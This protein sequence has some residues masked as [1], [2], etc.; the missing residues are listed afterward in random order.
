MQEQREEEKGRLARRVHDEL[1]QSLTAA[2]I[3]LAMLLRT[4]ESDPQSVPR[5][6]RS[7]M[8]SLDSAVLNVRRVSTEL[9]PGILDQMGL[10]P[11]LEWLVR[12]FGQRTGINV[13]FQC[14]AGVALGER[15]D[16]VVFRITQEALTNVARH[17]QASQVKVNGVLAQNT[18]LLT[19]ADDGV[20]FGEDKLNDPHSIGLFGMRERAL[21]AGGSIAIACTPGSGSL[22]RIS[23]PVPIQDVSVK[24]AA[25]A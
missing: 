11:A 9:R 18:F 1:G 22:I 25:S 20:G 5:R 21:A 16:I 12:E 15:A 14:D 6:V 19:I 4:A 3:D 23:V 2:K 13:H 17:A 10:E 24:Q 7:A 8:E